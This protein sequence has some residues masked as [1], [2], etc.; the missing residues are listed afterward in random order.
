MEEKE[1]ARMNVRNEKTRSLQWRLYDHSKEKNE[2]SLQDLRILKPSPVRQGEGMCSAYLQKALLGA[3]RMKWKGRC[4]IK[5]P[6]MPFRGKVHV[7]G[8][9]KEESKDSA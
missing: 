8:L 7:K 6:D 1:I 4:Q 5:N 9:S 3:K 2:A